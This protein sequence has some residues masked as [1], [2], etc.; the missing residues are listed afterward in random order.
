MVTRR[1]LFVLDMDKAIELITNGCYH[2]SSLLKCPHTVVEQSTSAPPDAVGVSFAADAC[3]SGPRMRHV[4]H[5]DNI[6]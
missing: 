1:Y 2:C 6:A 3:L 5:F 4:L